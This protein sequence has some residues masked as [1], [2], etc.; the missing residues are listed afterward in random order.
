MDTQ[1]RV[2]QFPPLAKRKSSFELTRAS[3]Q[4]IPLAVHSG[5]IFP[6]SSAVQPRS[7]RIHKELPWTTYHP[8][9]KDDQSGHCTLAYRTVSPTFAMAVV[10]KHSNVP[11]PSQLNSLFECA[12]PNVVR[13]KE[14]YLDE[15]FF[16]VY[17]SANVSLTEVQA[18]P[19]HSLEDF[20]LAAICKEVSIRGIALLR[21]C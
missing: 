3:K 1:K 21:L 9:L 16:W 14:A 10:K 11:T 18:C 6:L 17:E 12:H 15:E 19:S 13:L 2:T 5:S 8:L 7:L 4:R 20:E